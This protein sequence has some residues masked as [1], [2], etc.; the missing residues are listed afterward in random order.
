MKKYISLVWLVLM[1]GVLAACGNNDDQD[2]ITEPPDFENEQLTVEL[3]VTN[4]VEV[5]ETVDMSA[6]VTIGDRKIDQADEVIYEIWEEGK[7]AESVMIDAENEGE[8]IYTAE[9]SF[10]HDGTFHIQ[11]HVTAEVQHS[12]P[13]EVVTVGDGGEYEESDEPDYHTEGFGMH[14]MKPANVEAGEEGSLLVHIELHDDALED[15]DVRYEIW[16]ENNEDKHDWV[17]ATE[18]SAGEYNASYTFEEA[19]EYT[20]VIHVEDDEEL[21]EHEEHILEVIE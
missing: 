3:T 1:I 14:F 10:D 11:V 5:D 2:V 9:T 13:T 4:E 19:G 15:L 7:K 18:E 20:I 6:L 17:D 8:G 16:H 12:M 21:H